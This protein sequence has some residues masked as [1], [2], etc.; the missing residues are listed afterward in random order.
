[1][2]STLFYNIGTTWFPKAL[3]FDFIIFILVESLT[4]YQGAHTYFLNLNASPA[5]SI[6][7]K[8]PPSAMECGRIHI[9][10][11]RAEVYS[12]CSL[13]IESGP[14]FTIM[15]RTS[16]RTSAAALQQVSNTEPHSTLDEK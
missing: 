15:V 6:S 1:L 13:P 10:F 12:S 14:I 4:L 5:G 8:Y 11:R 3:K 2:L 16:Y 9:P 7:R